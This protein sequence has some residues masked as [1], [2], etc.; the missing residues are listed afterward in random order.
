MLFSSQT[1]SSDGSTSK[2]SQS[3]RGASSG[4]H[5]DQPKLSDCGALN[6]VK[7]NR[8]PPPITE[9]S[10][11]TVPTATSVKNEAD[12]RSPNRST[13]TKQAV[14]FFFTRV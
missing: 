8:R 11:Q 7:H 3:D 4:M 13:K 1:S 6:L 9:E 5:S 14:S 12:K 2:R 10:D